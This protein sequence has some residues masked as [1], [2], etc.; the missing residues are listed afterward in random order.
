MPGSV[1]PDVTKGVVRQVADHIKA[2]NPK[3]SKKTI[4]WIAWTYCLKY[5]G[6]TE[7]S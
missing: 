4:E 7:D 6:L 5:P 2:E 3:P 1:P